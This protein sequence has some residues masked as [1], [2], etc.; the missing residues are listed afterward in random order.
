M[1]CHVSRCAD[2]FQPAHSPLVNKCLDAAIARA[3][4]RPGAQLRS[5]LCSSAH[6]ESCAWTNNADHENT[7]FLT[8]KKFI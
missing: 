2:I 5:E 4:W 3:I 1:H 8:T 7:L 6:A